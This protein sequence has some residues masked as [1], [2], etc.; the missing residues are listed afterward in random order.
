[1]LQSQQTQST[2][3]C[4]QNEKA[5]PAVDHTERNLPSQH[6]YV[7]WWDVLTGFWSTQQQC[8]KFISFKPLDS[9]SFVTV[10]ERNIYILLCLLPTPS[11]ILPSQPGN[12]SPIPLLPKPFSERRADGNLTPSCK[13]R[14]VWPL[15]WHLH[16]LCRSHFVITQYCDPFDGKNSENFIVG[17]RSV[18][19]RISAHLYASSVNVVNGR[20]S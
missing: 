8:D 3:L 9:W 12:P 1:M 17:I 4:H 14:S 6:L 5:D 16:F 13:H 10:A 11:H 7:V 15:P 18:S 20:V 2:R 19:C